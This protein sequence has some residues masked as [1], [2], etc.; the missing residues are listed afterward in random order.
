MRAYPP[1]ATDT[2]SSHA[3]FRSGWVDPRRLVKRKRGRRRGNGLAGMRERVWAYGGKIEMVDPENPPNA[4]S[5][6]SRTPAQTVRG[7]A[8]ETAFSWLQPSGSGMNEPFGL[9]ALVVRNPAV[10]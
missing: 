10:A 2:P 8:G 3:V 4:Q 5:K 9:N 1:N 7:A 6:R